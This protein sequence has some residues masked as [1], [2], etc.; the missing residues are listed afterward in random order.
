MQR[1]DTIQTDEMDRRSKTQRRIR[2][3]YSEHHENAEFY[4]MCNKFQIMKPY[5]AEVY[6]QISI[7]VFYKH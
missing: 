5:N 4:A 2:N 6:T 3:L 1:R 7:T